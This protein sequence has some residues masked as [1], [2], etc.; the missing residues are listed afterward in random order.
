MAIHMV[1]GIL[2]I[3]IMAALAVLGSTHLLSPVHILLYQL[4]WMIPGLLV[5]LWPRTA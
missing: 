3:L 2:G 1:G 5:T 4:I